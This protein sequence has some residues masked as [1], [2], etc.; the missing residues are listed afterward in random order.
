MIIP[1]DNPL[2]TNLGKELNNTTQSV[3]AGND[4]AEA[5]AKLQK[6]AESEWG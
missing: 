1:W 5:F 4:A 3:L 2:G 6:A